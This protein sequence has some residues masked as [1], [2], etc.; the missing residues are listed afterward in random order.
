MNTVIYT[1][2]IRKGKGGYGIRG[3]ERLKVWLSG[4]FVIV[5]LE[6]DKFA[7]HIKVPPS[8]KLKVFHPQAYWFYEKI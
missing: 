6:P 3:V 4:T 7:N 5:F 2:F 8:A 1:S